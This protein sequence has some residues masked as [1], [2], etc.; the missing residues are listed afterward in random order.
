[1][2]IDPSTAVGVATGVNLNRT[3]RRVMV[4]DVSVIPVPEL[5]V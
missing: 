5:V 4:V 1:M 2:T 3:H